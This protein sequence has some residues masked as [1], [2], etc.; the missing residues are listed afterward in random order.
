[1]VT[2]LIS[3]MDIYRY[4]RCIE[5]IYIHAGLKQSV[6]AIYSILN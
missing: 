5:S 2:F 1:M 4:F 3:I 6:Y